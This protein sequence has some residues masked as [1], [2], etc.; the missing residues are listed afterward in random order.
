MNEMPVVS[1]SRITKIENLR[2]KCCHSGP[3]GE[4]P[5]LRIRV[6][7]EGGRGGDISHHILQYKETTNEGDPWID[8]A[9]DIS[10]TRLEMRSP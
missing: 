10:A 1:T 7:W 4:I 5:F 8:I 3:N 9:T 6:N 2:V